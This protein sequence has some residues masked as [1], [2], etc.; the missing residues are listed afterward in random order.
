MKG[1]KVV[2]SS[3][4]MLALMTATQSANAT[5]VATIDGCYDCISYDTPGLTIHNTSGGTFTNVQLF[6]SA[7][8]PGTLNFGKTQTVALPDMP[9][10]DNLVI[11]NGQNHNFAV[12]SGDLFSW[13]YDDSYGVAPLLVGNFSVTFSALISGGTFD[14]QPVFSVFS[15]ASNDTGG[16][17]GWEGLDPTGL[18]ETAYDQHSGSTSTVNGTLAHIDIG[19]APV[20]GPMVGAGLPG[21]LAA[22]GGVLGWWRRRRRSR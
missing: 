5:T 21:A 4:A 14:T 12:T 17:I 7:N 8:Q 13:D 11:W 20:P 9:V 1:L 19:V 3:V 22:F 18:A 6:L 16:F 15:P 10:G 2:M